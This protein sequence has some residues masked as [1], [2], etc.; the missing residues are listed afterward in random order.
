MVDSNS[1]GM[2]SKQ[3]ALDALEKERE[4]LIS[5]GQIEAENMLA[6]HAIKIIE[7]LEEATTTV[8]TGIDVPSFFHCHECHASLAFQQAYCHCC[9][10][11][12]KWW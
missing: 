5:R 12:I 2:I 10:R 4:Y 7:E 6:H 9:G 8:D 3:E 1:Y 11:R